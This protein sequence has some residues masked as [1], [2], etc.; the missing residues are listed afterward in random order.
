VNPELPRPDRGRRA[1]LILAVLMTLTALIQG[2]HR[3]RKGHNA[4]LKWEP[5]Y[6]RLERGQPIYA[7]V[8]ASGREGYP[9]PPI[10]LMLMAPFRGAGPVWGPLLWASFKLAIAWFMLLSA[11]RLAAGRAS[12]WPPWALAL[13]LLLSFRVLHSDVQHGNLNLVVAGT[14]VAALVS[15]ARG[16][17]VRAG[18]WLGI[19]T[20]LKVTPALGLLWLARKASLRGLLGALVGLVLAAWVLPGLWLGFEHNQQLLGAWWH[21]M[22]SPYLAGRELSLLQTEHINQSLLGWLARLTTDSVAVAARPGVH[23]EDLRINLLS[24]S[25]GAFRA[26]HLGL[27]AALGLVLWRTWRPGRQG[28]QVLGEGALAGLAMVMLSERSWKQHYV[29]L[30]L[31]LAFLTWVLVACP[32]GDRRRRWAL[33]GLGSAGLLIGL[34]G[35]AILGAR[36]SDLAEAWGAYLLAGLSLFVAIASI[37]RRGGPLEASCPYPTGAQ[38]QLSEE[39]T[40][41]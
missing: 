13:L 28:L 34:S 3:A 38:T 37:L 32:R 30:P 7:G 4:L 33:V 26:L 35:E 39:K 19:G 12:R 25:P 15:F 23:P 24:L 1:V 2:H 5:V 14:V 9:T 27:S 17:E 22:I 11:L 40:T 20:V 6:E 18:L 8:D 21:Q 41:P 29:L 10:T 36:G 31:A 16:R